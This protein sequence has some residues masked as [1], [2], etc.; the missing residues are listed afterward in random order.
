MS[1][2][3][4]TSARVLSSL[5]PTN[6]ATGDA[7][8]SRLVDFCLAL[9]PTS[10]LERLVAS[11][12]P[13]L[14]TINQT[15]YGPLVL[16]PIAVAIETKPEASAE[17][18]NHQLA[19]WTKAWMARAELMS[20]WIMEHKPDGIGETERQLPVLPLIR[21]VGHDWKLAFAWADKVLDEGSSVVIVSEIA[22][23]STSDLVHVYR[24]LASLRRLALWAHTDFRL[25]SKEFFSFE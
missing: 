1:I 6:I 8:K 4:R 24:L 5:V 20:K 12:P 9:E 7:V 16:R 25:W 13:P 2:Y 22:M 10:T 23:G 14:Q 18:G 21:V 3:R 17:S 11:Q 15:T 19:T